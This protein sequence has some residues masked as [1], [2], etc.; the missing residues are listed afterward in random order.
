MRWEAVRPRAL[1]LALALALAMIAAACGDDDTGADTNATTA[2]TATGDA[3]ETGAAE[4]LT[5]AI[6]IGVGIDAAYAPFFVAESEGLFAEE[7]LEDVELIQFSRGGEAVEALGAGQLDMAGNS[8]TTTL[9][10]MAANPVF[11]ALF[12][13]QEAGDYLKLV[14]RPDLTGFEDIQTMG[15]VPGLSEYN[16]EVFVEHE[17]LEG[18]EFVEADPAEIP[19]LMQ[20][21]D[22]DA[23]ILWEPW[24]AQGV[25]LGGQVMGVTADFGSAYVHWLV[26]TEEWL[27]DTENEPYA[28]AVARALA[29]A[30]E[31]VESDP[32][33][34]AQATE[35]AA[36]VPP[37]Q[38]LL[39]V[40][41]IDFEVRGFSDSDLESY[42]DQLDYLT[43]RG[44]IAEAPDLDTA[45]VRDWYEEAVGG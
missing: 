42:A 18:V 5:E 25:E 23:Y 30:S 22:I 4:S 24:P 14:G 44:L 27:A 38:T 40:E 7:G 33:L 20:R 13:Y 2:T 34:A 15:V 26:V 37:D 41:E 36:S 19:A 35:E 39:A 32:E 43:N 6:Q 10:L 31:L 16:A 9:T 21:G 17:G 12:I 28:A 8:D 3:A 11:R 29:R 45:V 1:A